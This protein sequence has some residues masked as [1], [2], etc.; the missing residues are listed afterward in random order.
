MLQYKKFIWLIC[1]FVFL[2][3]RPLQTQEIKLSPIYSLGRITF[4]INESVK[5]N[6]TMYK[7]SKGR[8]VITLS[9]GE[10][11]SNIED[12]NND[13]VIELWTTYYDGQE[14][15][16]RLYQIDMRQNCSTLQSIL[17]H[18]I[19]LE[20]GSFSIEDVN[21]D[22]KNELVVKTFTHGLYGT[23]Y[24]RGEVY[25][26]DIYELYPVLSLANLNYKSV[27]REKKR[28]IENEIK[29]LYR[30]KEILENSNDQDSEI[31]KIR[32]DEILDQIRVYKL[33]LK[34]IEEMNI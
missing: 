21:N 20:Q 7:C 9:L 8:I 26:V 22:G 14:N 11:F 31:K 24:S 27:F 16:V 17:T 29:K 6:V 28:Q 13:E 25:W 32:I 12:V 34:K 18:Q 19:E 23:L 30:K 10:N 33:W 3:C 1:G 4:F 2:Q 15:I 5:T